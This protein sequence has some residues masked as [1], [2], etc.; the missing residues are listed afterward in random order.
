MKIVKLKDSS[1]LK[2]FFEDLV[3]KKQQLTEAEF[4]RAYQDAG[5]QVSEAQKQL[6]LERN[7]SI[8]SGIS[9][10]PF[11]LVPRQNP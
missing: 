5:G 6:T 3:V 7:Q 8:Q 9:S 1:E 4:W 11:V 2:E 10:R